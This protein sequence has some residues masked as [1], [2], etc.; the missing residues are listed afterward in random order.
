M[1]GRALAAEVTT[2]S[3][4]IVEPTGAA[5]GQEPVAVLAAIDLGIKSRTPWQFAERGVR[6]HV[7]PQSTTLSEILALRPDGVLFSNGPGDPGSADAETSILRGVLDA[8]IPF[9]GICL[10][11]QLLGRAMG[12][13]TYKLAYGHRGVNQ[14]VLDRAT[15]KVEITAHNHGFAVDAPVDEPSTAP[16][17]NGRYGRVEVSHW[18]S[19]TVS[20]RGYT[21]W[22]CRP[23]PSSTTPRPRPA[24]TT[25]S[26]S[27]TD[28]SASCGSAARAR[29]ARTRTD[30]P[31]RPDITSV[32]VIGSGPIVIG[33]ACEFDYSGT[34]A[35]RVL[36]AEG[37][38][39]ILVNSNPATIMTDPDVADAT[40][41]EP[42]TP[43]V[44]TTIIAKERPD[45]LLPTLGGQTALNA[46]MSLVERGV[47]DEYDVEL[48]GASAAAINAGEDRDEFKDVV[49]RCGAEVARSVIA[50]TMDECRAGVDALGG[51]PVVV[52]PSFTM[53]GLGSGVAFNDAGPASHRGGGAGG[54][55]HHRG[56][57]GGVDPGLEGVRARA[58]ARHRRQRGGRV[59]H[60]E[61]RPCGSAYRR[62]HHGRPGPDPH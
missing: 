9:F 5:D 38:R 31:A 37:I 25:P 4:Y 61:R 26:T 47:L 16:F 52:R 10:G 18:D 35:C 58:H 51:Y 62:L 28:S 11:N 1:S 22:T 56:P 29:T 42:I 33:Q 2:P 41:I 60:R 8:H 50:H 53:G 32:L 17:D 54:L 39:V 20:S 12:Y 21:R 43:E 46:A 57:P 40:Y 27:S 6:V 24:P 7:L 23:S 3:G 13:G 44:L 34:Q 48:I 59:L 49:E 36:R 14:P 55:P 30:M 15:G 45:A 19:T